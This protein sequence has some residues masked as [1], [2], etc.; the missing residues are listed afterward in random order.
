MPASRK[1]EGLLLNGLGLSFK[2][3]TLCFFCSA[4]CQFMTQRPWPR[5]Q[6]LEMPPARRQRAQANMKRTRQQ[7][8]QKWTVAASAY[9]LLSISDAAGN[10]AAA[11]A[12]VVTAVG[13][14]ARAT[15]LPYGRGVLP[16]GEDGLGSG[17]ASC[18]CKAK[19]LPRSCSSDTE[20]CSGHIKVQGCEQRSGRERSP[21]HQ[22]DEDTTKDAEE[23]AGEEVR[24]RGAAPELRGVQDRGGTQDDTKMSQ[25]G[26]T[27]PRKDGREIR[28]KIFDA[29]RCT[30][31]STCTNS[32]STCT[33]MFSQMVWRSS[34]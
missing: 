18:V 20:S 26:E 15:A 25:V 24:T 17:G 9:E 3:T 29:F 1:Y 8:P 16:A 22:L 33:M 11:A 21:G 28:G 5:C 19:R 30:W 10:A 32:T 12:A 23:G 2:N 4:S 27:S 6:R 31:R 14:D 13:A 34:G 7:P